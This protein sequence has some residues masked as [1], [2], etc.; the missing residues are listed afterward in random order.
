MQDETFRT[1]VA[2]TSANLH[3][4]TFAA[5]NDLLTGYPGADGIKTG[6]TTDAGYCLVGSA[7]RDGRR[8]IVAV[9]GSST[10]AT[11]VAAATKLLDWGFAQT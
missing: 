11:R 10:D 1:T 6:H 3:G 9:M 5:T 2:R 8:I 4:Q 7:T